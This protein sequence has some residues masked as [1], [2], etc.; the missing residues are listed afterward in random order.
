[1]T[2]EISQ[3]IEEV[4]A[5]HVLAENGGVLLSE[6]IC[7]TED[8]D[9]VEDI[10]LN[11]MI[12]R[13]QRPAP[14]EV[15]GFYDPRFSTPRYQ[16]P[17]ND[18]FSSPHSYAVA[19]PAMTPGLVVA[20]PKARLIREIAS[21]LLKCLLNPEEELAHLLEQMMIHTA[22]NHIDHYDHFLALTRKIFDH[23]GYELKEEKAATTKLPVDY[24]QTSLVNFFQGP[25]KL[26]H[27][28]TH[29]SKSMLWQYLSH[30]PAEDFYS[31]FGRF[32]YAQSL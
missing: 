4:I 5:F 9:W 25:G 18:S 32:L 12:V 31:Y 7:L 20:K 11:P 15:I 27:E 13:G 10:E 2:G 21:E 8:L 29:V 17:T 28:I 14:A 30:V 26:H 1:M 22:N 6:G 19:S 3:L 24:Y 23:K 16:V